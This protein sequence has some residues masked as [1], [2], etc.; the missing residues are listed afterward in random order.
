[1]DVELGAWFDRKPSTALQYAPLALLTGRTT[2][3]LPRPCGRPAAADADADATS[4]SDG[5]RGTGTTPPSA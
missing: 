5:S 4:T 3:T 2:V 1:M